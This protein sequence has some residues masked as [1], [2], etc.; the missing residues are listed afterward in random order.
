[1]GPLL[2]SLV[3]DI[4]GREVLNRTVGAEAARAM[5]E[6]P[7]DVS[8]FQ[9]W[10]MVK[11][12]LGP[13]ARLHVQPGLNN[14]FYTRDKAGRPV[15]AVDPRLL[16]KTIVQ[17]EIG[18][19]VRDQEGRLSNRLYGP[20][21]ALGPLLSTIGGGVAGGASTSK[22]R[23]RG[24]LA[25]LAGLGVS[26]PFLV[27]ER[28]AS[29]YARKELGSSP[30]ALDKA[31]NTYLGTAV[32]A[33]IGAGLGGLAGRKMLKLPGALKALMRRFR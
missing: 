2:G 19:G 4:A 29:N 21:I 20:S 26:T 25:A 22:I 13:E 3:G 18:H 31:F 14:A 32:A 27:E 12:K 11:R 24:L 16:K 15:V 17:H 33:P 5:H 8:R 7:S 28:Q 30:E 6:D 1:M 23:R 10:L 9:A